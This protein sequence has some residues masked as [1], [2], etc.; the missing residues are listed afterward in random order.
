MLT[1]PILT[2]SLPG[3]GERPCDRGA[4]DARAGA[5]AGQGR[6]GLPQGACAR[7]YLNYPHA[8]H[9]FSFASF[10]SFAQLSAEPSNRA[11]GSLDNGRLKAVPTDKKCGLRA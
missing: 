1:R 3:R 8:P 5:G 4:M 10:A 11:T 6:Q 9:A 7:L 2:D